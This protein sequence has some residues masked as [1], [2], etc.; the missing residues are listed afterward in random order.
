M[1]KSRLLVALLLVVV[2]A[3]AGTSTASAQPPTTNHDRVVET[4]V[5]WTIPAGQCPDVPYE[6]T[7]TGTR[8]QVINTKVNRDGSQTVLI[9]DVV[10]G[11]AQDVTGEYRFTYVNHSVRDIPAG[12][13][14][15]QISMVDNFVLNG[16]GIVGHM[17]V[18]FN[19][20]WTYTPPEEEWPP[21]HNWEQ[22]NTRGDPMHCDP[23]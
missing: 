14:T 15:I 17:E 7:G 11:T 22:L 3:A 20:R 23:L 1:S 8:R 16:K 12:G 4:D 6:L 21:Q 2:L 19:W 18:G 10:H 9:N 13:G 5:T